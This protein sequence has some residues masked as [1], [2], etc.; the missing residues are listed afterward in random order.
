[1]IDWTK[2]LEA[3]HTDGRVVPVALAHHSPQ[4][5]LCGDYQIE[6]G[7]SSDGRGRYFRSTGQAYALDL[8]D[9]SVRNVVEQPA[10]RT[11]AEQLDR[12]DAL[13]QRITNGKV[14]RSQTPLAIAI[15]YEI[16]T[17]ARAIIA[18]REPVD[19]DIAIA[20]QISDRS[21]YDLNGLTLA[22]M[23]V[24]NAHIREAILAGIKYGRAQ[25]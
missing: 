10:W 15:N 17:E 7:V 11:S 18:A 19:P 12:M 14:D 3:V 2:P 20:Q 22:R 13:L 16:V 9:W 21:P 8:Q 1:M 6:R 5:D 4:P 23:A 24:N 25:K